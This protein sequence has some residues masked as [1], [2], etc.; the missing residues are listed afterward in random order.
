MISHK[1]KLIINIVTIVALL[2]L[3][4]FSWPDI[5]NGLQEIGGAN[6]YI[7]ALMIPLQIFNFFAV[8]MIYYSFFKSDTD[9]HLY[10][11]ISRRNML[12]VALELNFINNVFPSGGVA[13]F[14]YLGFRMKSFGVPV[15]RTTLAQSLRF[16]LTFISF[17]ILLFIG[18]FMLSFGAQSSG[19]T[20]YI[21]LSIAFLTLFGT[22]LA[23]YIVSDEGRIKAFTAFLPKIINS[24][25]RVFKKSKPA[26]NER[27]V[28]KL[29]SELHRDYLQLMQNRNRLKKP[30]I[31][32]L[33][34]N[35]TE[36][37]TI[38][39]AYLAL[40]QAINP[41]A[42][43]LAYSVASF[44]GLISILP[45]GIGVYETLMTATLASAGV[46]KALAL[47]ATLIYRI[48]TMII[49]VPAG[50]I[51]YQMALKKGQAKEV[52]RVRPTHS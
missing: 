6:W 15:A 8:G 28:E 49:F 30:F 9:R 13:G 25:A 44:A 16:G 21:G 32:A 27:K 7:L 19:V 10:K 2:V 48:F 31:W 38:Y 34:V 11:H 45:G 4:I 51:L 35:I 42:V 50:F 20:L 14:T 36:V 26:I 46:P 47:S 39:L 12:R 5:T 3:I 23:I 17:L 18:L 40:G 52:E 1:A 43:I 29:F 22:L 24:V 37:T 41:G 33:V